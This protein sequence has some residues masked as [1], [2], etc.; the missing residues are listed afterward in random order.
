MTDTA[1]SSTSVS[2]PDADKEYPASDTTISDTT[3]DTD[4]GINHWRRG[5]IARILKWKCKRGCPKVEVILRM[6]QFL[7]NGRISK[8]SLDAEQR[9]Y[10][11]RC[12][13]QRETVSEFVPIYGRPETQQL[14]LLKCWVHFNMHLMYGHGRIWPDEYQ[15]ISSDAELQEKH[16][17]DNL[18][19]NF[20]LETVM[21]LQDVGDRGFPAVRNSYD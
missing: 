19:S 16:D 1:L 2:E 8:D 21:S 11:R 15:V 3:M 13:S 17:E 6:I 14:D 10:E 20:D 7:P 4:T 12:A 18:S 5:F 9:R